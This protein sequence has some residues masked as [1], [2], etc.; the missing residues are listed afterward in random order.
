MIESLH[1]VHPQSSFLY[2]KPDLRA[3]HSTHGQFS[4]H[5]NFTQDN[6]HNHQYQQPY[7]HQ[8]IQT[9]TH[10][11]YYRP[12]ASGAHVYSQPKTTLASQPNL[13]PLASPRPMHQKASF[14]YEPEGQLL[15]LDTTFTPELILSPSTPTLSVSGSTESSPPSTCGIIHT[16]VTVPFFPLEGVKEGCEKEVKSEILAGEDWTRCCSPPLT[17]V[18]MH[19]RTVPATQSSDLLPIQSCPSLSPSPSPILCSSSSD[20]STDFCDPRNLVKDSTQPSFGAVATDFPPLPTLCPG[21]DEEHKFLLGGSPVLVK[22]ESQFPKPLESLS[23]ATLGGFLS[24][25]TFSDF[26]SDNEFVTDLS[27]FPTP[28]PVVYLGSKKQRLELVSFDDE[29]LLSEDSFE[30]FEDL[31]RFVSARLPSL[32]EAR[33]SEFFEENMP[34]RMKAKKRVQVKKAAKKFLPNDSLANGD[35]D[36]HHTQSH[37]TGS[38][39]QHAAGSQ[40]TSTAPDS[41]AGSPDGSAAT[42]NTTAMSTPNVPVARRGRKQSL[43]DDPSKTFICNLCSRRFRR[44]E[45]LKRHYRSLHTHDKPFEC[46]DCGKRFSRSDNLSQHARTH[47][48]GAMVMG[49]LEDGELPPNESSETDDRD[50]GILGAVL[51]E[52]AQAATDGSSSSS[53]N[54]GSVRN[55]VSPEPSM[56][57]TKSTK[58]RKRED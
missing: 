18:F 13:T 45:H 20:T 15:S 55:S 35:N 6:V 42:A 4:P 54:G 41:L 29:E 34:S 8:M 25:D 7:Q 37:V 52:A 22:P 17:P 36:A 56:E 1:Q 33:A 26:D 44:Q 40:H 24:F 32:P 53:S 14:L 49:V 58:K 16:P 9:Q 46:T 3:E 28:E 47:G 23:G 10:M 31:D 39:P 21:D 48:S 51:F 27:Q 57:N 50:P 19:H 38:S 30:D 12:S 5:P 2:W 11:G 43:T